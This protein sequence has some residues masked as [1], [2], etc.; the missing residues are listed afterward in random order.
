MSGLSSI[1]D[2]QCSWSSL[3]YCFFGPLLF[4][5]FIRKLYLFAKLLSASF[6]FFLELFGKYF[7]ARFKLRCNDCL[8]RKTH[9]WP[10][11][12]LFS[13]TFRDEDED[14]DCGV[15]RT[16][17]ESLVWFSAFF[18]SRYF[19]ALVLSYSRRFLY[20]SGQT[21]F[22]YSLS[23]FFLSFSVFLSFSLFLSRYL[24]RN[25]YLRHF[26]LR[27]FRFSHSS[28]KKI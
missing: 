18:L 2:S 10:Y 1:S 21:Y 15:W 17:S 26:Y 13:L 6:F 28:S 27:Q 3:K 4:F 8:E 24:L 23:S 16:D 14:E 9:S 19:R 25:F 20:F 5:N 7:S 11:V 12:G 22:S